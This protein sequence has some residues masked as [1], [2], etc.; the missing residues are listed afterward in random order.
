M[1]RRTFLKTPA[2]AA[3]SGQA[4]A[5]AG[6]SPFP[7]S[8]VAASVWRGVNLGGWLALEK[9]ISPSVYAGTK[10]EDE[11]SLCQELGATEAAARL[12]RHRESWITADDFRWL[13]ERGLNSVR[14]PINYGA[15]GGESPFVEATEILAWAF[16]TAKANGIGVLLDL[17]GV[18]GSQNGWDHS[19]RQGTLGWHSSKENVDHSLRIVAKLAAW[20]RQHDNLIGFELLNEP[21]WDVPLDFLKTFYR[22]AYSIVRSDLP[23]DRAAVVIHDSFRPSEWQG[24]MQAPEFA[25]VLLDTHPYQC[26]TDDDRARSLREQVRFALL[27][28]E[29]LVDGLQKQ[30]PCIVGEWSCALPPESLQGRQGFALDVA[31]RGYGDAQLINYEATRGWFF[32]TYKTEGGGAWSFRD[33]VRHGWLPDSYRG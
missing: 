26:Y 29:K 14:L 2:L 19:G 1:D 28:R 3:L 31:M 11:F 4:S 22:E 17:H 23:A 20:C 7:E 13:A 32:W 25:N 21:R 27:E 5:W 10:A 24:F 9:W 8:M 33:C 16:R 30:L 18:P 6:A 12:K 15:L